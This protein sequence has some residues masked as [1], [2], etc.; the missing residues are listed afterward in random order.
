MSSTVHESIRG[1]DGSVFLARELMGL[2]WWWWN[3]AFDFSK[4]FFSFSAPAIIVSALAVSLQ[5][6]PWALS[7]VASMWGFW[8]L[9]LNTESV[10]KKLITQSTM[11]WPFLCHE[12]AEAFRWGHLSTK[13]LPFLLYK[14]EL[15]KDH[16]EHRRQN[17]T[18]HSDIKTELKKWGALILIYK[19]CSFWKKQDQALQA[20]LQ[21]IW[22]TCWLLAQLIQHLISIANQKHN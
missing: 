2:C 12:L 19:M 20:Q 22:A 7:L 21:S 1:R 5:V 11:F 8:L 6:W 13:D 3:M 18:F 9:T 15:D 4:W 14:V 17:G 10:F 16:S